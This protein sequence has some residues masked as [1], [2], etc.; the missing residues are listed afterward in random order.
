MKHIVDFFAENNL[1]FA[2]KVRKFPNYV[3]VSMKVIDSSEMPVTLFYKNNA[4]PACYM[5]HVTT[6]KLD[7]GLSEF[8]EAVRQFFSD[9]FRGWFCQIDDK[10]II[11]C[12][13]RQIEVPWLDLNVF[14][15][16]PVKE[17]YGEV[18]TC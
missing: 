15:R 18:S 11:H 14:S 8:E 17:L 5:Q 9:L 12:S 7:H 16:I 2:V 13:D 6:L 4:R 10:A 1:K 3:N